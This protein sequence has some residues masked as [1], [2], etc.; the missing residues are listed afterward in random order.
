MRI[1]RPARSTPGLLVCRPVGWVLV[2]LNLAC[3]PFLMFLKRPLVPL[4]T[5]GIRPTRQMGPAP[6]MGC[7]HVSVWPS[8][9]GEPSH[10]TNHAKL[11]SLLPRAHIESQENHPSDCGH[12]ALE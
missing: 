1:P 4:V 7:S 12:H 11:S 9:P 6:A 8:P 2:F 3:R 5:E 10:K